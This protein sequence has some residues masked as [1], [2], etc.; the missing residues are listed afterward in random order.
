MSIKRTNMFIVFKHVLICAR[1]CIYIYKGWFFCWYL[2]S[3]AVL[4][5]LWNLFRLF[6]N[7]IMNRLTNEQRLQIIEFYYQNSCSV[8]RVHRAILPIY[9]KFGDAAHFCLNGYVNKQ[10][11]RIWNEDKPLALHVVPMHPEKVSLVWIMGRWHHR[12]VLLQRRRWAERYCEWR[13]LPC[14][15]WRFFFCP[16]WKNWTCLTCSFNKTVP[17]ATRHAQQW[18]NWEPPSVNSLSHVRGPLIGRLDRVI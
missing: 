18:P 17:H 16:K 4:D 7:F 3:Y 8:K 14:D 5:R 15:D 11:S 9:G 12:A 6:Y 13:A 10:N 2:F 1:H